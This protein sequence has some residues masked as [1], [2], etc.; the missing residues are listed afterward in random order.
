MHLGLV[1]EMVHSGYGDRTAVVTGLGAIDYAGLAERSWA[2]STLCHELGVASVVYVGGNHLAYPVSLFGAAGAGIP[3]IP[4]NYRL[5]PDRLAAQ[6]DAHPG[7]T[8]RARRHRAGRGRPRPDPLVPVLP[9]P[10]RGCGRRAADARRPGPSLHPPLHQRDDGRPQGGRA[11]PPPPHVLS[12]RHRRVRQRGRG[13]GRIG[14]GAPV[15]H[16]R[17]GQ[18]AEQPLRRTPHHLPRPVRSGGVAADRARREGHPGHGDPDHAGPSGDPPRRRGRCRDAEPP[19]PL[20]R[21]SPHAHPGPAAGHRALPGHRVRQR[22]R[23]HRDQFDH[24]T[25]RPGGPP[26]RAGLRGPGGPGPA[27]LGR[28]ASARDRARGAR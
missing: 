16:R 18:P 6:I 27:G 7:V 23:A 26:G 21:R 19:L 10:A 24:R 17:S 1:L 9:R 2:A 25:A 20:L 4:L 15:P 5:G 11:P 8:H 12:V 3:F 14:L 22:L 13:R 28:T